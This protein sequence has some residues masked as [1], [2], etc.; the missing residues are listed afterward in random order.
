MKVVVLNAVVG[1]PGLFMW[2]GEAGFEEVRAAVAAGA[3]S[4]V[5]HP[6]TASL[7]GVPVSRGEYVPEAGDVA[8][9]VRLKRR[10]QNPG[11]VGEVRPEDLE[12]LRV[13]Y[14]GNLKDLRKLAGRTLYDLATTGGYEPQ[15]LDKT[16]W[17]LMGQVQKA[18]RYLENPGFKGRIRSVWY[19]L[20]RALIRAR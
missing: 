18:Q 3:S 2:V 11:D 8:F 9:V 7:L 16:M 13:V 14:A 12:V 1:R 19:R 5:G 10:L 4:F 17:Y 20:R 15:N 6:A